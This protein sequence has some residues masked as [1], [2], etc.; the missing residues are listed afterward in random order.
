MCVWTLFL[1]VGCASSFHMSQRSTRTSQRYGS[2]S[3]G[4][5]GQNYGQASTCSSETANRILALQLQLEMEQKRRRE[6]E[7]ALADYASGKRVVIAD[8]QSRLPP[9]TE[10]ALKKLEKRDVA[11]GRNEKSERRFPSATGLPQ[12]AYNIP[13]APT[14]ASKPQLST[15]SPTRSNSAATRFAEKK[16]PTC[17]GACLEGRE[18]RKPPLPKEAKPFPQAS[19]GPRFGRQKSSDIDEYLARQRHEARVAVL[20]AF[21]L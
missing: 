7:K 14:H 16:S 11:E 21:E 18:T 19:V 4:F 8:E 10:S 5:E 6:V 13:Q 12:P 9:L 15:V 2:A 20:K 17:V 1:L 3:R